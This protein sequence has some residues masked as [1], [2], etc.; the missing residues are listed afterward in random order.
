MLIGN[1][2]TLT[3]SH[4]IYPE[5]IK[6]ALEWL[7][8][9]DFSAMPDG[10]YPID[11]DKCFALVSRYQTKPLAECRAE[12]HQKYVDIQYVAAG[13]E[14][15]GWCPFSPDLKTAAAYDAEKDIVFYEKLIPDS[16]VVLVPG[17]FAVLYPDDVHR[18]CA[19]VFEGEPSGVTKIVV[20]IAVELVDV[21]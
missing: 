13:E 15:L 20:K 21:E 12:S 18:P 17:G 9:Q 11:G 14:Y 5:P 2:D 8:R 19:Q 10:R 3:R 6:R 16:N 4:P 1:I 7:S